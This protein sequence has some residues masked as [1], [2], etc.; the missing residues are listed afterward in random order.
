METVR[1]GFRGDASINHGLAESAQCVLQGGVP[2]KLAPDAVRQNRRLI[3]GATPRVS[4][5]SAQFFLDWV[6][7]RMARIKLDDPQQKAEVMKYHAEAGA[8]WRRKVEAAN[9]D[10]GKSG[11]DEWLV[12][13]FG[14]AEA[15][16][17]CRCACMNLRSYPGFARSTR[18]RTLDLL[19]SA[20]IGG[21]GAVPAL[22][23]AHVAGLSR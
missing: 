20:V 22:P 14:V 2:A 5:A 12:W 6:H 13:A 17:A 9:A 10:S 15:R 7:E 16:V 23:A 11:K 18:L 4:R 3:G 1:S 8:F 19:L 21:V